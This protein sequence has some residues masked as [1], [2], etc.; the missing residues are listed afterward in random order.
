MGSGVRAASVSM[1]VPLGFPEHSSW[2][3]VVEGY[4]PHPNEN[5]SLEYSAVGPNY[6][7]AMQ[8]PIVRGRPIT[9]ADRDSAPQV[10][11]VNETFV[12]RYWPG[13]DPIGRRVNMNG[14]LTVVGVARDGK[15]HALN[16]PPQPFVYRPFAQL[17]VPQVQ[18]IV[19]AAGDPRTLVEPLRREFGALDPH[20]GFLD[21]R[22]LAEHMG[23]A[24]LVQKTGAT[25]LG[26]FVPDAW[27]KYRH[28]VR[29]RKFKAQLVDALL[30]LSS[31][32]RAGLSLTQAFEQLEAE[33]SPPASQEFGLMLKAHRVGRTLEEALQG[34]NARMPSEELQLMTTAV[35]VAR[36]TGGD[37]TEVIN[38][39]VT[40]IRDRQKLGDKV[41]TL[42]LQGKLQAYLLSAL[43][44]V[45]AV[46]VR[47][48]NP[49]FFNVLL[50]D[51]TGRMVLGAA[52]VL[53][54]IGMVLLMRMSRVRT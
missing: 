47:T 33:I 49:K 5:M 24:T 51:Q 48:F 3:T 32:L 4:Q 11:V 10:A 6:F 9:A 36:E 2:G 27:V 21:P 16:E 54:V 46:F 40:T 1:F 13:L 15:Y 35:L 39:L 18:L 20:V 30:I 44:V 50:E 43:P 53:W 25:V 28:A 23:A 7:E 12:R 26:V 52:C 38:Q 22:T 29:Q 37:V 42:T 34:L 19:R 41:K 14:W 45:F 17:Y 31:S 8:T